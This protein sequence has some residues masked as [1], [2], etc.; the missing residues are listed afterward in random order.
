MK[1]NVATSLRRNQ[2]GVTALGYA[3][4][5]PL[6][7]AVVFVALEVAFIMLADA[8]LDIAANRVAR[9]GRIGIQGNCQ[10][11][12][13]GVMNNTLSAWVRNENEMYADAKIYTPGGD[14]D[15][16]DPGDKNYEP[17]CNAGG[18]GDMVIYR[19]AFDRPG[20]T[21]FIAWLGYTKMRFERV[22]LIQ[23]EP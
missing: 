1:V 21:G 3:L 8:H 14:N 4:V 5:A 6:L 15:F 7:F 20:L 17:V 2:R 16:N 23:N 22:I 9:M 18:R 12:V 13:R 19:L 11:A 10:Q